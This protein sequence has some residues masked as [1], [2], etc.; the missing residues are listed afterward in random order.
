MLYLAIL[1]LILG[2]YAPKWILGDKYSAMRESFGWKY[3]ILKL[4]GLATC[5]LLSFI[6]TLFV[7]LSMSHQYVLNRDA[8]YGLEFSRN[9][10]EHGFVDGDKIRSINGKPVERVDQIVI[11]MLQENSEVAVEIER[12]GVAQLLFLSMDNMGALI[13]DVNLC[14]L[15]AK[16]E[17]D[18]GYTSHSKAVIV[19]ESP[20]GFRDAL[21]HY[22]FKWRMAAKLLLPQPSSYRSLGGFV[23]ISKPQEWKGYTSLLGLNLIFVCM[24]NLIPLPGFSVGNLIV[25]A[26]EN[27]RKRRFNQRKIIVAKVFFISATLALIL[28]QV[29]LS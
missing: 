20:M 10:K 2:N 18:S 15:R 29:F 28:L 14:Q 27:I 13:K 9:L 1:I 22:A 4:S 5:F 17:P 26:V 7:T 21:T 11:Q 25:S 12:N 3:S 24:V 6:I 8:I 16:M 19:T 23:T